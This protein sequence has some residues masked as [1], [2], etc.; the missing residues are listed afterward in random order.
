MEIHQRRLAPT[1]GLALEDEL[2]Q[3]HH[4]Y[5]PTAHRRHSKPTLWGPKP[6]GR[7]L[8]VYVALLLAYGALCWLVSTYSGRVPEP[9]PAGAPPQ[10]FSEGR[11]RLHLEQLIKQIGWRTTISPPLPRL[12]LCGVVRCVRFGFLA[13]GKLVCSRH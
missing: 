11:A 12:V 10:L 3:A 7:T 9:V 8:A 2:E 13:S 6:A 4:S 5:H 1:A